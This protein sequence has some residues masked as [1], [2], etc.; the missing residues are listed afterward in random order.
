MNNQ[1]EL[2]LDTYKRLETAAE[3]LVG[4]SGRSSSVM[5]LAHL[6]TFSRYREELDYCRQVR[7]LLTH[8]A[9]I[10]GAYG[11][12]P[13]DQLLAVL[14]KVLRQIED[15]PTVG[16]YMTPVSRLVTACLQDKVLPF[17]VQMEEKGFTYL[18][19]IEQNKIVGILA[20][21]RCF[22]GCFR[23]SKSVRT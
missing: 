22:G 18:P 6:P 3:S 16:E 11:V 13:S 17:M 20:S 4:N 1:A 2:F 23:A 14:N 9:K 10:D 12:T 7:N 5:R 19:I 15:P 21:M 8:E